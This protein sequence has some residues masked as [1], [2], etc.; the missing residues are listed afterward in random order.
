MEVNEVASYVY[1]TNVLAMQKLMGYNFALD[2]I[3]KLGTISQNTATA[4]NM[5]WNNEGVAPFYYE[6][7]I[8]FSLIDSNGKVA[9]T[10]LVDGDITN[11]MPGRTSVTVSLN[12]PT[13]V[14]VGNYTLAIAIADKDTGK[15]AMNLA[16]EG[17]REDGRY[18]LYTL[19][20]SK[21][22]ASSGGS[23]TGG[24][25]S[26]GSSTGGTTSGTTDS[27]TGTTT[28]TT[29]ET[30]TGTTTST[31]TTTESTTTETTTED[32]TEET[33]EEVDVPYEEIISADEIETVEV[34]MTDL[35]TEVESAD[36]GTA[37]EAKLEETTVVEPE[38]LE[39]A[40]GKNVDII[41]T[42]ANKCKWHINGRDIDEGALAAIDFEVI[43]NTENIPEE[44]VEPIKTESGFLQFEVK[45]N[46][47]FGFK[48]G[49]TLPIG[50]ENAGKMATLF[51]HDVANGTMIP[52]GK[53]VVNA[54]GNVTFAFTHASDY[55]VILSEDIVEDSTEVTDDA[56]ADVETEVT[57]ETVTE[58]T[59]TT[60]DDNN[61]DSGNA[62][63]IIILIVILVLAAGV[64]V[65]LKLGLFKEGGKR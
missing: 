34:Q 63:W 53:N 39:S 21:Q 49:L 64:F 60:V 25:T 61:D 41:L 35:Q 29:T 12:V 17:G 15:P 1:E 6:W 9:W 26:G 48:A 16:I 32:V 14:N 33:T 56:V 54:N 62:T 40:R 2:K 52:Q 55:I 65:V 18:P 46:G 5:V 47:N 28:G 36:E 3:T 43:L 59:T 24:S 31:T 57:D 22:T 58:D 7:P 38:V 23:S 20:V 50:A 13:S 10:K 27:T 4:I 37:L 11:W 45:H 19:S 8:E 51:W 30:T 42:L 44:L